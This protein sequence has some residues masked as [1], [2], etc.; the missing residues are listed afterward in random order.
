MLFSVAAFFSIRL[1]KNESLTNI[2]MLIWL[3]VIVFISGFR[4]DLGQDF[5]GYKSNFEN[6]E[7]SHY[8]PLVALLCEIFYY[9]N[10]PYIYFFVALSLFTFIFFLKFVSGKDREIQYLIVL[11]FLALPH[12][13]FQTYNLTRQML[14]VVIFA[15]ASTLIGSKIK[16]IFYIIICSMIHQSVLFAIPFVIFLELFKSFKYDKLLYIASLIIFIN[17]SL[18]QTTISFLGSLFKHEY[19]ENY[20]L[21]HQEYSLDFSYGPIIIINIFLTI[22]II[23]NKR[24]FYS[25]GMQREYNYF[26]IGQI[27]FNFLSWDMALARFSYYFIFFYI[28]I[29]P[30]LVILF[31]DKYKNIIH[32]TLCTTYLLFFFRMMDDTNPF[33]PYKNYFFN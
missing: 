15:Y 3:I 21:T 32:I 12:Y 14:A 7:F 5:S 9:I 11:I 10:L 28:S 30:S 6:Q 1:V 33:I 25:I 19:S 31:N 4:V 13:Y 23:I 22:F 24:K 29:I 16:Y 26:L 2:I 8:E 20:L 27:L 18:I 17:P